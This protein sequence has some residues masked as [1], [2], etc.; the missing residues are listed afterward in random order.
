M[1]VAPSTTAVTLQSE[2]GDPIGQGKSYSYTKANAEIAVQVTGKLLSVTVTGDEDWRGEFQLADNLQWQAARYDNAAIY[3]PSVPNVTAMRWY[4]MG[5][6]CTAA[7][8]WF[9]VDQ[10]D[11]AP[12]T[13]TRSMIL[14]FARYCDGATA[15]LK[16]EVRFQAADATAPAAI[17]AVPDSKWR[18]PAG[19][20]PATGNYVYLSSDA[21]DVVGQGRTRLYT[22]ADARIAG[23]F[24]NDY[25]EM[26]MAGHEAWYGILNGLK[27]TRLKV[28]Y[29]PDLVRYPFANPVRGGLSWVGEGRGCPDSRGWAAIDRLDFDPTT[30]ALQAIEY[31]FE[32]TCTG[33]AGSLRGAVRWVAET[34]AVTPLTAAG[35]WRAPSGTVPADGNY[36]YF[37]STPGDTLARGRTALFT[38]RDSTFT[39]TMTGGDALLDINGDDRW[40]VSLRPPTNGTPLTKGVYENLVRFGDVSRPSFDVSSNTTG[41]E[42]APNWVAIDDVQ[43]VA[44]QVAVL[45]LRFDFRCDNAPGTVRGEVHWRAD[46]KRVPDGP[47]TDAPA[48]LWRPA[49]GTVPTANQS[50]L[51]VESSRADLIGAGLAAN[52]TKVT[53][54]MTLTAKGNVLH[55]DVAGDQAWQADFAGPTGQARLTPGFY[56]GLKRYPIHDAGR[57]GMNVASEGHT[58]NS[59]QGWFVVDSISYSAAGELSDVKLRFEQHVEGS[60][61]GG[62]WGELG[63]VAADPT[64]PPGPAAA[65]GDLWRASAAGVPASG[66]YLVLESGVGDF[67]GGGA[68][69]TLTPANAKFSL[70]QNQAGATAIFAADVGTPFPWTVE[71]KTMSSITRLQPGFYGN[72]GGHRFQNPAKGGLNVFGGGGGCNSVF[73]WFVVDDVRYSGDTIVALKARFEQSCEGT[74]VLHGQINW[75]Q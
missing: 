39:L 48:T 17:G 9:Q 65:P 26:Y 47:G 67:I 56:S 69:Q 20:T 6:G 61:T 10:V 3:K 35:S 7:T 32:Q 43:Y 71:L 1:V 25:F 34:A 68:T 49:A 42:S 46:D 55:L 50:Y 8:G 72:I 5:R 58:G 44:G 45:N 22:P 66:N 52:Y 4:G 37:A 30:N 57:G 12:V 23:V 59:L 36:A 73:G 63:W 41:C 24:G 31:R 11:Q 16:G 40:F 2:A 74:G 21:S 15:A 28:G 38:A 53:A 54:G 62:L 51:H 64:Q 60:T 70:V 29:Y 13:G 18:P 75:S 27:A 14:R 33:A 19:A